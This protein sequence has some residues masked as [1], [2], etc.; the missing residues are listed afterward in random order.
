M[1]KRI[2]VKN[3]KS[4]RDSKNLKLGRLNTF[5]GAN[6]S[7]K[8]SFIE[9]LL[10]YQMLIQEGL[11]E[12]MN[13]WGGFE[14]IRNR[15]VSHTN[16]SL[17]NQKPYQTNPITFNFLHQD[18]RT[19]L[20]I[21]CSHSGDRIFI[22]KEELQV[23]SYTSR[24]SFF[25]KLNNSSNQR[26]IEI[27]NES[28]RPPEIMID[29][30]SIITAFSFLDEQA[31]S[32]HRTISDWQFLDLN[33]SIMGLPHLQRR[34][35][36]KI[37]LNKNGSNI[38]EYLLDIREKDINAF[39]G[40]VE[41][42]QFILPYS[43]DLQPNI[44]SQL[45]RKVYLQLA[46]GNFKIPGWLLSTGTLR[47]VSIL[48]VLRHPEPPPLIVIEEIENGLDPS[49]IHLIIN[50]IEDVIR[51]EKTQIILTTHSPYLL[52]LLDI[53][54]IILVERNEEGEPTF[55]RPEDQEELSAWV[56]DFGVGQLYTMSKLKRG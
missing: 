9:S 41:T 54:H 31:R 12:A 22:R 29:D 17:S 38:A 30:E 40:I 16:L 27:S 6:G 43:Q 50:E 18:W 5:I 45:E 20:Q 26:G 53:S 25:I 32:V 52:D 42:L 13:Y 55:T 56:D 23:K 24:E 46:E 37:K 19:E 8:S 44:T 21:T 7:G 11:D 34:T 3:F 51:E 39:N 15:A 36:K 10:T 4:I 28:I 14:F 35:G 48:A 1:L 33:P 49:T 2:K 47:L